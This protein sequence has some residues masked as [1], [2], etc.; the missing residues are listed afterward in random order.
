MGVEGGLEGWQRERPTTWARRELVQRARPVRDRPARW[1]D[2]QLAR[3]VAGLLHDTWRRPVQADRGVV[4]MAKAQTRLKAPWST[5][6]GHWQP[7]CQ[8]SW[9]LAL[10]WSGAGARGCKLTNCATFSAEKRTC[11]RRF[12]GADADSLSHHAKAVAFLQPDALHAR[13]EISVE[14]VARSHPL[15]ALAASW[16]RAGPMRPWSSGLRSV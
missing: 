15:S 10:D 12:I 2:E 11:D 16:Q 4:M 6:R 5:S 1:W 13:Y 8:R 14:H 7:G 9:P 3:T